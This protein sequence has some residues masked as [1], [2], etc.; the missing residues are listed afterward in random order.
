[1]V[2]NP[3]EEEERTSGRLGCRWEVAIK[4]DLKENVY[5]TLFHIHSPNSGLLP[6]D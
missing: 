5:E 4:M 6:I 1:L 2:G 3:K